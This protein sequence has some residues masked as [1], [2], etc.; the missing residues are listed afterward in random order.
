[1][2]TPAGA[3]RS[4]DVVV[5]GATGF[6]GRLVADYLSRNAPSSLRWAIAGRSEE[7]LAG[8]RKGLSGRPPDGLLVADSKDPSSLRTMAQQTRAVATTVG[9]Y[10]RYGAE[11]VAAC[12]AEA[13]HYCDLTGEVAFMRDMI[14]Q[15]HEAARSSGARIVHACGFDSIPSD[16]GV[17]VLQNGLQ[18]RGEAPC[19]HVKFILL[20]GKGGFSGGTLESMA[21]M[22]E[23]VRDPETRKRVGH[24]YALNP[25]G[26]RRG[27]DRGDQMGAA[28]DEVSGW[29][30]GPFLMAAVNTRV[31][32]RSHALTG[33]AYGRDFRYDE[34]MRFGSGLAGRAKA[35]AFVAGLGAFL[36]GMALPPVRTLMQ[37]TFL[38]SA[39]EG[40]SPEA[41]ES[42]FFKILLSGRREG[43]EFAR[44]TV[45]GRRDP[46]YG[47]T[48]CMLSESAICLAA[49][50]A[51]PGSGGVLTPATAMGT[52]LVE[53]LNESD[54]GFEFEA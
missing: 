38:P 48:A 5:F 19:E 41:I 44:V 51:T 34:V 32:R 10:A 47:A 13:T 37:K 20:G 4:F 54:V 1:M 42:G 14:E 15:H 7:K 39:G 26:E 27:P 45:T 35:T 50:P 23:A 53:R 43:R 8:I 21:M 3:E 52:E 11:L 12:V 2:S 36:G 22:I 9:P 17:F 6:T 30:T 18:A 31:V 49:Q 46:G 40:P 28:Y 29:W 25:E 16:L 33:W 24:P